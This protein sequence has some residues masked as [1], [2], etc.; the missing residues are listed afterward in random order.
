MSQAG[1]KT[2]EVESDIYTCY[3]SSS[4]LKKKKIGPNIGVWITV[5]EHKILRICGHFEHNEECQT[6]KYTR[7]PPI[8]VHPSVYVV[9]LVQLCDG[10]TFS[11]AKAYVDFPADIASS[12]FCWVLTNN[13][14]RSRYCQYS[15]MKGVSI[16]VAPE[17]NVDDWL[18]PRS[19]KYNATLA[20]AIFHYSA[21]ADRGER[22]EVAIATD[23]MNRAAWRYGHELQIILDGTFG[24]CESRLLLFIVM[25]VDENR[26]GVPIAF[27]L[28]SAPT[29][30][31][32]SSSSYNTAL[33]TKLLKKWSESLNKSA[34]LYGHAG[35]LFKPLS[36]ITDTD[37]KEHG[38]WLLKGKSVV[39]MD[40]KHRMTCLE[41]ALMMTQ[42]ITKARMLLGSE[43]QVMVK[44]FVEQPKAAAKAMKH[45]D[46]LDTHWTTD[47]LWPS[48]SDYGRT[49]L[50]SMLGTV[51]DGVIPTTNYLESFNQVLKRILDFSVQIDRGG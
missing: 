35:V 44:L 18:N 19:D 38:N 49:V 16:S 21:R 7:T 40:L 12:P 3:I 22:F 45:I 15:R 47:N 23:D 42:T 32:Q 9:A 46:Y 14:S 25:A 36:A 33:L 2:R 51:I 8:P 24:V 11:D 6:A 17:I 20:N 50:T 26:K 34:H 5:H 31:R 30:N 41:R 48:W 1:F 13:D 29:G 43:R 39:Y 10:A 27:L 4:G 37:L 28:F